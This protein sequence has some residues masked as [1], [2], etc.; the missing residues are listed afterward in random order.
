MSSGL[1]FRQVRYH[2]QNKHFY[3]YQ[4]LRLRR[5]ASAEEIKQSY[6]RLSKQ[7][8]PDNQVTGDQRKFIAVQQAY[9]KLKTQISEPEPDVALTH[10]DYIK[11]KKTRDYVYAG[12][13]GTIHDSELYQRRSSIRRYLMRR[14]ARWMGRS[15]ETIADPKL[16]DNISKRDY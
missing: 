16:A 7:F 9:E 4:V 12:S 15:Y 10:E 1:F 3:S 2:G 8:H 11:S 14:V 6:L 5:G 13:Y